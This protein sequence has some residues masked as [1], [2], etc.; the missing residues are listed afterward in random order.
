ML[1]AAAYAVCLVWAD[2]GGIVDAAAE[3]SPDW[4]L[5]WM[6][7]VSAVSLQQSAGLGAVR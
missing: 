5:V 3:R 6:R 2:D 4:R 1:L 7:D